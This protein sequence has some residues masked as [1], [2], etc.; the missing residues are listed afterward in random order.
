M[1]VVRDGVNATLFVDGVASG[2]TSLPPATP[3]GGF[4]IAAH[5][6]SP[7]GEF[8]N[9]AVDE[10]RVFTFTG[11]FNTNDLLFY[12]RVATLPADGGAASAILNGSVNPS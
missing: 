12:Q 5:P 7:A 11:A 10:V 6:Q 1:A 9:G 2:T 4:A 3:A 8:F